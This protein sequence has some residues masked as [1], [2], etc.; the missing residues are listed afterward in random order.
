MVST[1][2]AATRY[3]L[4]PVLMTANI[5]YPFMFVPALP[6]GGRL[7]VSRMSRRS[8]KDHLLPVVLVFALKDI[9][10]RKRGMEP[11]HA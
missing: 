10:T 5:F 9:R 2:L 4:P 1:S 3:C 6:E 7:F 8:P 11:F